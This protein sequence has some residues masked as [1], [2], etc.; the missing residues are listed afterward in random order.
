VHSVLKPVDPE[1]EELDGPSVAIDH[2]LYSPYGL[3][4]AAE[5]ANPSAVVVKSASPVPSAFPGSYCRAGVILEGMDDVV[6]VSDSG[7]DPVKAP[8][9]I[10]NLLS[11]APTTLSRPD[12]GMRVTLEGMDNIIGLSDVGLAS[13]PTERPRPTQELALSHWLPTLCE[14]KQ[15]IEQFTEG[16]FERTSHLDQVRVLLRSPVKL[17]YGFRL[18]LP[19]ASHHIEFSFAAVLCASS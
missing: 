5:P 2:A 13:G 7:T 15:R 9:V 14:I 12:H 6:E 17:S 4:A 19:R 8:L 18:T 3:P 10:E 11:P 1:S 16:K